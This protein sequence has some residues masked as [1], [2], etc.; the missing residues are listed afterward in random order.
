MQIQQEKFYG[1][2]RYYLSNQPILRLLWDSN[3]NNNDKLI[4]K[5]VIRMKTFRLI[6]MALLALCVNFAACSDD[7]ENGNDITNGGAQKHLVKMVEHENSYDYVVEYLYDNEGKVS[8]FIRSNGETGEVSN[9]YSTV[10]WNE[11]SVIADE[12]GYTDVYTLANGLITNWN[13]GRYTSTYNSSRQLVSIQGD[14]YSLTWENGYVTKFTDYDGSILEY[15]YYDNI[16]YKGYAPVR[17]YDRIWHIF[18][19]DLLIYAHPE[20]MGC[21]NLGLPEIIHNLDE[22]T[23]VR[24]T[25]TFYDDGYIK[26][27]TMLEMDPDGRSWDITYE[28]IWE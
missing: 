26:S 19:N 9:Y 5:Q 12:N 4:Y 13:N 14:D 1:F 23:V 25:Y 24:N 16:D 27:R 15:T 3:A 10:S 18:E 22:G 2:I 8:S 7:E 20:L 6:G 21:Q 11:N 17:R 28:Y